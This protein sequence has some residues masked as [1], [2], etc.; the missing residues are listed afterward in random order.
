MLAAVAQS[1]CKRSVKLYPGDR[2][3]VLSSEA[4]TVDATDTSVLGSVDKAIVRSVAAR[5]KV[6]HQLPQLVLCSRMKLVSSATLDALFSEKCK[7]AGAC[8]WPGFYHAFSKAT[9]VTW[10]SL[11]GYSANGKTAVVF[12]SGACGSLCGAGS[13]WI[14]NKV[15]GKWV[16]SSSVSAWI[17]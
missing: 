15:D 1:I 7:K 11:P 9:G 10:L 2:Y 5:N 12:V 14:L 17:S 4:Q 16:V 8:G 3:G 6:A 13:F